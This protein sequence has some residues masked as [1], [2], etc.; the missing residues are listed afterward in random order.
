MKAIL[1]IGSLVVVAGFATVVMLTDALAKRMDPNRS[2]ETGFS[3]LVSCT[4]HRFSR[5]VSQGTPAFPIVFTEP[6]YQPTYV[7]T[8]SWGVAHCP[9]NSL[10]RR[11]LCTTKSVATNNDFDTGLPFPKPWLVRT[12]KTSPFITALHVETPL[13]LAAALRFYRAELSKRGWTE[14]GGVVVT[15]EAATIAFTTAD[16]PALLRLTHQG[17]RTIADLSLRKT[18]V[19]KADMLP[20]PGQIRLMLGNATDEEAVITID[21]QTITLAARAGSNLTDDPETGHKSPDVQ[22]L[23]LPPG[24]HKVTL[25]LASGAA[26]NREFE[27]AADETWGLMVGPAGV[28]LP[29]HIY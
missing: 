5:T 20:R 1:L 28:A 22:D 16:G 26:Q 19:A 3:T 21:A 2:C 7:D 12:A 24:K 10:A 13:D 14:N 17:D 25:K 15:P 11:L 23:N 9:Q 18:T 8:T 29:V 27:I 6:Y 4:Y